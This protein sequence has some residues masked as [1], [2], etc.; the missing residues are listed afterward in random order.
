MSV[1]YDMIFFLLILFHP[2]WYLVKLNWINE[3]LCKQIT[4]PNVSPDMYLDQHINGLVQERRNSNANTL[5]LRLSCTNPSIYGCPTP[6]L[7]S[8]WQGSIVII[9]ID[10][11]SNVVCWWRTCNII[12]KCWYGKILQINGWCKANIWH[13]IVINP[14]SVN[15]WILYAKKTTNKY[16]MIKPS[17]ILIITQLIHSTCCTCTF[18]QAVCH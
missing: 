13:Y 17:V 8:L 4:C 9:C 10:M 5:E 2:V 16:I 11:S 14:T 18:L 1:S 6:L 15:R 7:L 3:T 12:L